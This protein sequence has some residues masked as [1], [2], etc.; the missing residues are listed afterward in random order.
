MDALGA[1]SAVPH[2]GIPLCDLVYRITIDPFSYLSIQALLCCVIVWSAAKM[3]RPVMLRPLIWPG[4]R[5]YALYLFH[6]FV[7]DQVVASGFAYLPLVALPFL[8]LLVVCIL[9]E[10]SWRL[11]EAPLI[12]FAKRKFARA[13]GTHALASPSGPLTLTPKGTGAA[14]TQLP[15]PGGRAVAPEGVSARTDLTPHRSGTIAP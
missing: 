9:A 2:I 5:C 13:R 8:A 3:E 6:N 4:R 7:A 10:I 12:D 14:A 1:L 11:M 15:G